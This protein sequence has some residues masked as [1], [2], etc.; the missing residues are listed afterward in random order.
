M[1]FSMSN[2]L[3]VVLLGVLGFIAYLLFIYFMVKLSHW[4]DDKQ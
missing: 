4:R 1:E 3:L 2:N